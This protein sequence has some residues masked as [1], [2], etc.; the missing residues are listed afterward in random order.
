MIAAAG[1]GA[2]Q[3]QPPVDS[4]AVIRTETRVVLV[5]AVVTDKKGAYVR[6]LS[7]KDFKVWEDNKEQKITSFSFEADPAS[8]SSSLPRYLVLFFDNSTMD[9]ANQIQARNAA[10]NFIDATVGPNH[11]MAV[12]NYGGALSIAQNFTDNGE[13]LKAAVKGIQFAAV[14]PNETPPAGG[15]IP[16]LGGGMASFG[17]RSMILALRDMAKRLGPVQGRKTLILFTGGFQVPADQLPEVTA[18]I[19]QCNR[20]NVAIYPIDVRG[21]VAGGSS[22]AQDDAADY[23]ALRAPAFAKPLSLSSF[24]SEFQARGGGGGSIGGGGS[25]SGGGAGGG[26]AGGGAGG[27]A[28]GGGGATSG[29]STGGGGRGG[30]GGTPG[31]AGNGGMG[32][33][34]TMGNNGSMN[35]GRGGGSI[36]VQP[37]IPN[38]NRSRDLIGKFPE[39]AATNQQIMY[40]LAD[41]TGGFVIVNTNDLLSGL[42]KIGKELNEYYLLGYT[43][44][45]SEEGSCHTLKVKVDKGAAARYRTGYCNTKTKDVLST[46]PIEKTL[47]ARAAGSQP[48]TVPARIQ[49]PFFYTGPNVARV[50]VALEVDTAALKF[51]KEKGKMHAEMN[52][53]GIAYKPDN[54]V[55]ARFSDVVKFDVEDKKAVESFKEK[56]FHYENQFDIAAGAYTLKIVYNTGGESFGKQDLPLAI[57]PYDGK[58]F[59]VSGVA[60]STTF[61][62][63]SDLSAGTEAALLEDRTP[64]VA[65]G[66]QMTPS[67]TNKFAKNSKPAVY[68]EVYEPGLNDPEPKGVA[69]ALQLIVT[70]RK[71]G[72]QKGDSGMFRIPLP[73]KGGNPVVP[74][75]IPIPL[76]DPAA[77]SYRLEVKGLNNLGKTFSRKVDFE[78][79]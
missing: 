61:H 20:S 9:S 2:Q 1:A 18:T 75:G 54:A 44:A 33:G 72:E 53:L 17:A 19:D 51:E 23:A 49:A 60:F 42:Q 74:A 56:P 21:L 57:D 55:A 63:P 40:M 43:P 32:R 28:R 6:D 79:E 62:R 70:D 59:A 38:Y 15:R 25:T 78:V 4:G 41:G 5:D 36:P 31:N 39:S 71:T 58:T 14:N 37:G 45:E 52:V 69:V 30:I 77:G 8:P 35:A 47:E 76:A 11:L 16:Q 73:E 46:Q 10:V 29:G 48:G 22:A 66:I 50:N 26:T 67:G 24:A 3:Q 12:V 68:F 65:M 64:L 34:S 13:R 7:V 27:G